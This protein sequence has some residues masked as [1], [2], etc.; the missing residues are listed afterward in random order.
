MNEKSTLAHM[1]GGFRPWSVGA[2]AFNPVARQ[3]VMEKPCG[4]KTARKNKE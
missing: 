2:V 1:Y 4:F 3:H